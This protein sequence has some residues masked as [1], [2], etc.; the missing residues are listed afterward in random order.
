MMPIDGLLA[1][2]QSVIKQAEPAKVA[3][4]KAKSDEATNNSDGVGN[5][6]KA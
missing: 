6:S 5:G 3:T 1:G 2:M 4:A